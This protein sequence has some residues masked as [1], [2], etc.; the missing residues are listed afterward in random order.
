MNVEFGNGVIFL[1]LYIIFVL[2]TTVYTIIDDSDFSKT[3]RQIYDST[4]LNIFGC[5]L[6]WVFS[7]LVNPI[8][9]VLY[10]ISVIFHVGRKKKEEDDEWY[11]L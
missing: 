9:Y 10:F 11:G 7:I 1:T 8:S 4:E 2:F 6:L 5:V 3:P